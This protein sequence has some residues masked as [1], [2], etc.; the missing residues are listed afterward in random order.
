MNKETKLLIEELDGSD[1][2][3]I[4]LEELRRDKSLKENLEKELELLLS[5]FPELK[6]DEI[7]DEV[8]EGCDN[9][10][11]LAAQYALWYVRAQKE[12]EETEKTN[13]KN[14]ISAPPEVTAADEEVFFTPEAVK[15]MSDKDIRRNYKAIMKS[16]EKWANK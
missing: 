8:F 2:D 14:A 9:G 12:K 10:K 4:E 6:A 15:A 3:K 16:M 11:G 13:E 7:P 1:R 5:I